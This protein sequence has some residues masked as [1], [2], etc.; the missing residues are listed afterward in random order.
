M[1][2]VLS[3][4]F[5]CSLTR[6][7]Q[8]TS[9]RNEMPY[10]GTVG[11]TSTLLGISSNLLCS[12]ISSHFIRLMQSRQRQQCNAMKDTN[13]KIRRHIFPSCL[14]NK[15]RLGN[16]EERTEQNYTDEYLKSFQHASLIDSECTGY[17]QQITSFSTSTIVFT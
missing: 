16:Q 1:F 12:L 7:I 5:K 4:H 15:T 6:S 13:G 17:L 8:L 14:S 10:N 2:V 9:T 11:P 3:V